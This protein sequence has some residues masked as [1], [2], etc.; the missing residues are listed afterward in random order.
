MYHP[1]ISPTKHADPVF[2]MDCSY[3]LQARFGSTSLQGNI[4]FILAASN[5]LKEQAAV[6]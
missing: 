3:A 2:I 6:V 5:Q 1:L 4:N